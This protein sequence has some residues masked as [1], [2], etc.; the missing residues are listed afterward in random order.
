LLSIASFS[1]GTG[2][3]SFF[4][5]AENSSEGIAGNVTDPQWKNDPA[6]NE[7]RAFMTK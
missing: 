7:W 3:D 1:T 4:R 6:M 5:S 2:R